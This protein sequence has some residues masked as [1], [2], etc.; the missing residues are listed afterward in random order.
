MP[1][2]HAI[3]AILLATGAFFLYAQGRLRMEVVSLLLIGVIALGFFF[4]PLP[5]EDAGVGI[6]R[7]FGGFGSEALVTICCMMVIG[8]GLVT[9]GAL[10]PVTRA[11]GRV[12][13]RSKVM[14]L[15]LT[16]VFAGVTSMFINDT[17]VM[18]LIMPV[19]LSIS[20][21]TGYPPSRSL[22]PVNFAVLVGGM[23][24]AIGTSTN[25]LVTSIARDLGVAPIGIF[26]FMDIGLGA[27]IIALPYLWLV[28]PR[29]LPSYTS[30]AE[31]TQRKFAAA[32]FIE[33]SSNIVDSTL[34]QVRARI[35]KFVDVH[36]VTRNGLSLKRPEIH[37]RPGD[38]VQI[39]GALSDLQLASEQM[40][41]PL[42][43]QSIIKALRSDPR[44]DKMIAELVVGA[45]S[46][47]VGQTIRG[48][49]FETSQSAVIIGLYRPDRNFYHEVIDT[50]DER[51]EAG[52]VLLVQG[53]AETVKSLQSHTGAMLLEGAAEMPNTARSSVAIAIAA[54][55]V[56][57]AGLHLVPISISAL[58]GTIAMIV[59]GCVSFERLGRALSAEVIVLVAASIAL[60]KTMLAT[61]AAAWLGS[62]L[63]YALNDMPAAVSV[64]AILC[65]AAFIT[66]FTSNAAAAAVTTPIAV[67]VAGQLGVP[68]EAMVLAVLFG[69][70]LSFATPMAYQTN[71]LIMGPGGYRFGD[72]VRTGVPLM[73]LMIVALTILL[74]TKYQ[75]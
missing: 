16:L 66:N 72:Y 18:I 63:A 67:N 7:A 70:N 38:V 64:T 25:L 8:R 43:P 17:P 27:A 37:I 69:C 35:G 32:L 49:Q 3:A 13:M 45:N 61:G 57:V 14:G 40:G 24:T 28:M 33:D 22:L 46:D 68:P 52:D 23:C 11:M 51:L 42:A 75:L 56:G 9:T 53:A 73:L 71:F 19:L 50:L 5:G 30:V 55:V 36:G 47:L 58:A 2:P 39:E 41:A 26:D 12:W 65:F 62:G 60:G 6:A 48:A 15:L 1:A 20:A 74:V 59:T 21:R 34:E 29:M 44:E 54:A 4:F 31:E 10:D